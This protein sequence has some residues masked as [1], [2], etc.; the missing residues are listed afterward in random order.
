MT[1]RD[2][3]GTLLGSLG[4]EPQVIEAVQR[5]DAVMQNMRRRMLKR[6]LGRRA[7][8]TLNLPLELGQLDVLYAIDATPAE[9]GEDAPSE[10]M[11]GTVAERLGIDPSRASRI[12]AEM[13]SAGYARRAVSQA[14]GRRTIVELTDSGRAVVNAV[15]SYKW[16]LVGEHFRGWDAADISAF[17]P[18]LERYSD[19][20][21]TADEGEA[22]F[23]S[24]IAALSDAVAEARA[25]Q[26]ANTAPET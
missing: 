10:T 8:Q 21:D 11:V 6:E 18:L 16:L 15:R 3:I 14:D 23:A 5:V 9:F 12:V 4:L 20:L 17:V 2:D 19:W 26:A 1:K 13:V 7:L 25:V 22:R 24:E